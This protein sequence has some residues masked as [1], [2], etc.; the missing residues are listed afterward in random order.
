M[1]KR[2]G[3]K[4][5]LG[6]C[7]ALYVRIQLRPNSINLANVPSRS[8]TGCASAHPNW[9]SSYFLIPP[10]GR[11]LWTLDRALTALCYGKHTTVHV[12]ILNQDYFHRCTVEKKK[13]SNELLVPFM[14]LGRSGI[15]YSLIPIAVS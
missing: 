3:T 10:L 8:F 5:G 15:V 6:R 12:T 9:P 13:M 4:G 1:E 7:M 14:P 11:I 2:G